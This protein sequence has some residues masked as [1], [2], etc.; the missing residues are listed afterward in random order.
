MTTAV[1][2][3]PHFA[4]KSLNRYEVFAGVLSGQVAGLIMAAVMVFVF[5]VVLGTGPLY[6]V[7]II[8][9]MALGRTALE[10]TNWAA[11]ALGVLL[12]QLGPALFWG[13]I[14][15]LLASK[16]SV[17]TSM[18]AL[19]LG[20]GIGCLSMIGPYYL[21]PFLMNSMHGEDLWNL[22]VPMMWDWAAHLV[23][24]ASF[25]FYPKILRSFSNYDSNYD[26]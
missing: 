23:Y 2:H 15:G 1:K 6:P 16:F 9:S 19:M 22:N 13:F 24:G 14:Y 11:V 18:E 3:G 21:I 7:Q 25:I 5:A 26:Y 17:K 10:G 20:L 8:G 4:S 12:H